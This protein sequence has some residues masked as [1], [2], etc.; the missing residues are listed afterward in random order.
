[1]LKALLSS[2]AVGGV[3]A[4]L[5]VYLMLKGWSLIGDALSHAVVP[6]VALAYLWRLPYALGAFTTGILAAAA[7]LLLKRLPMLR[8][9]AIIGFV[10]TLFFAAGLFIISLY[11]TAVNLQAVIYG[12]ILGIDDH[13]LWQMLA[14][15]AISLAIL[16]LKWRDLMLLFFDDIQATTAG[17]AV[18]RLRWLFFLLV[19][20]AVV[21]A[22]QTV[23]A[24]LVIALLIAPGATAYLLCHS[25]GRV[26]I[27][28]F[29]IGT[30]TAVLGTYLSYFVN[31]N[32]GAV[33]VVLQ[34]G[35]FLAVF[36]V[37]RL[38]HLAALRQH[39]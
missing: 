3:C 9:D 1:M 18:N 7:M 34:G 10:F 28:A 8:Q 5:S 39:P 17:L 11:P 19:S 6:G 30:T 27:T 4:L 33:V 26:L 36:T 32:T 23:G 31:G 16:A 29:T 2:A 12:N 15:C 24:I 20:A 35:F 22:L 37:R 21:A 14:I 13:D 25:F 38:Q